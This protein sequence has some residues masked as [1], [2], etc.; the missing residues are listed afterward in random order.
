M[1]SRGSQLYL[2]QCRNRPFPPPGANK[3]TFGLPNCKSY[4]NLSNHSPHVLHP[5]HHPFGDHLY[6]YLDALH[7]DL[8]E[9]PDCSYG[10]LAHPGA[11]YLSRYDYLAPSGI[12]PADHCLSSTGLPLGSPGYP[13]ALKSACY[14]LVGS[15][16]YAR[17]IKIP[18]SKVK[19]PRHCG[20]TPRVGF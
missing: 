6:L 15:S 10:L 11:R 8:P 16:Y 20:M 4:Q 1:L 2:P 19:M 14:Q 13:E 12:P 9:R 3:G 7:P 17:C 5:Q 18:L